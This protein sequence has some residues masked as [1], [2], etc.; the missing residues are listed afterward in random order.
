MRSY[1]LAIAEHTPFTQTDSRRIASPRNEDSILWA[2][3]MSGK[4][5]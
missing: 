1:P 4:I 2:C 3:A 5:S